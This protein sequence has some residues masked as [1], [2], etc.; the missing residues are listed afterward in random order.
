MKWP[1]VRTDREILPVL[2]IL[3]LSLVLWLTFLSIV[4]TIVQVTHPRVTCLLVELVLTYPPEEVHLNELTK[5]KTL[6][7]TVHACDKDGYPEFLNS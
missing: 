7:F 3:T 1:N 2:Q 4:P 5:T 6:L